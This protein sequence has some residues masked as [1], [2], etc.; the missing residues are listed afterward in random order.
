MKIQYA[1]DLHLEFSKNKG[2]IKANPIQPLGDILLLAGDIM[3]FSQIDRHADFLDFLAENFETTYWLPGNHEYYGGDMASHGGN[4][5]EKIRE[6][7]ILLNNHSITKKG[8]R[9]IFSTL[10]S[11]ISVQNEFKVLYGLNDFNHIKVKSKPLTVAAYNQHHKESLDFLDKELKKEV[12]E[13]TIVVTH[14]VPTFRQY[15][16]QYKNDP[17]N[18]AFATE[19]YDLIIETQPD[20]WIYGHHH[21]HIPDFYIGKTRLLTNQLGYVAYGEH[22]Q[23]ES[24]KTI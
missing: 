17:L 12:S 22:A 13:T 1:S 6:N 8:Y 7:I 19:L 24:Q 23:F 14:H 9:L 5:T 4:F 20:Y 3:P 16:E 2:F 15:P 18:E 11:L 10:W 21:S